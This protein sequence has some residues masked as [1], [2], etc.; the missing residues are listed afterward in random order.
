MVVRSNREGSHTLLAKFPEI[1]R[2]FKALVQH[3][4]QDA[5]VNSQDEGL[6]PQQSISLMCP[7]IIVLIVSPS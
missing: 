7:F 6:F 2:A 3:H 1:V 5:G 4:S